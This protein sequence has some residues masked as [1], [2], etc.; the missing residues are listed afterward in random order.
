MNLPYFVYE[1][2]DLEEKIKHATSLIAQSK[3]EEEEKAEK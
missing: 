3:H 2:S 1:D